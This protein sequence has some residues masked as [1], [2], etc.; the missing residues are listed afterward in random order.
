MIK[1]GMLVILTPILTGVIF[2]PKF[3]AG[4]IPGAIVSGV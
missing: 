3:V 1:P 2:G 4:L